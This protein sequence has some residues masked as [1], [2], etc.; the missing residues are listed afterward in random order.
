MLFDLKQNTAI[1]W[2]LSFDEALPH[3]SLLKST[4]SKEEKERSDRFR[5]A[6]DRNR[7]VLTRGV[8]R[9]LLGKYLNKDPK[10]IG[11]EYTEYQKPFL[12]GDQLIQ[13]NVGHSGGYAV[14]GFH[15]DTEIGVD[16]EYQKPELE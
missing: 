7:F 9:V 14:L 6:S 11:F 15:K 1:V 5:F 13:F 12:Q 4:L 16:V 3:L 10:S 2:I 8:L